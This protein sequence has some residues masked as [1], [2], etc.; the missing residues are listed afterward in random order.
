MTENSR[1][2]DERLVRDTLAGRQEAFSL[3]V[4]R[5]HAAMH[6]LAFAQTG[7]HADADDVA[8]EGFL[9]AYRSLNGLRDA[10]KFGGW[11]AAIVR[12][13]AHSFTRQRQQRAEVALGP[14]TATAPSDVE[15]RELRALLKGQIDL[16]D[17][18]QREVLLLHY[19]ADM[20]A[21]E[22]GE[23][24]GLSKFAVQKR[25]QRARDV[26]GGKVV[27]LLGG[28][29]EHRQSASARNRQIMG[30]IAAMPLPWAVSS[31]QAATTVLG[32]PVVAF[33]L[34]ALGAVVVSVSAFLWL[35]QGGGPEP[36]SAPTPEQ[37][38]WLAANSGAD[39]A[40]PS[41]TLDPNVAN[42]GGARDDSGGRSDISGVVI[43]TESGQGVSDIP[44]R[45]GAEGARDAVDATT[46]ADGRFTFAGVPAGEYLVAVD[47]GPYVLTGGEP[48]FEFAGPIDF[49]VVR[50]RVRADGPVPGL[51]LEVARGGVITGRVLDVTTKVPVSGVRLEA[52][53]MIERGLMPMGTLPI[54]DA[55]GAYRIEGLPA[56]DYKILCEWSVFRTDPLDAP[57]V[58]ITRPAEEVNV[59]D[60]LIDYGIS[61]TGRVVDQNGVAVDAADVRGT[62]RTSIDLRTRF[63]KSGADG[64]FELKGTGYKTGGRLFLQASKGAGLSS[65]DGPW[66]ILQEGVKGVVLTLGTGASIAGV[67]A[68]PSGQP[69]ADAAVTATHEPDRRAMAGIEDLDG[70]GIFL[71]DFGYGKDTRTGPDGSY[72]I[73]GL[74]PGNY[75]MQVSA[76][77][78]KPA[79]HLETSFLKRV[80]VEPGQDL[81]GVN[82]VLGQPEIDGPTISGTVRDAS[83]QPVSKVHVTA[84]LPTGFL[85]QPAQT[86][87]K[88]AYQ[89]GGLQGGPFTIRAEHVGFSPA[90]AEG[91]EIGAS[92]VDLTLL[93]SGSI[94]GQV[95]RADNGA[96]V[97]EFEIATINRASD[98]FSNVRESFKPVNDS[99]GRFHLEDLSEGSHTIFVKARGF[100]MGSKA[101]EN[102]QPG[103]ALSNVVVPLEAADPI[104][105][106]VVTDTG[107][108][109]PNAMILTPYDRIDFARQGQETPE[110]RTDSDGRFT[111]DTLAP[112]L[113][114]VIAV[115]RDFAPGIAAVPASGSG[116]H[117]V[118]IVLAQGGS[119]EGT[120]SGIE[121]VVPGAMVHVRAWYPDEPEK[122]PIDIPCEPDGTYAYTHLA[123]G[124][125]ELTAGIV[126]R[127]PSLSIK[128]MTTI[129]EGETTTADF[130]FEAFDASIEGTVAGARESWTR[131]NV[132]AT[133]AGA[134]GV[135]REFFVNVGADG[136]YRIDGVPEGPV[137]LLLRATTSDDEVFSREAAAE[138]VSGQVTHFDFEP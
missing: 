117:D 101:I 3:L 49:P 95:V 59:E 82:L 44:V 115:H 76:P 73:E 75:G 91:I 33:K 23:V 34:L 15:T 123:P 67:A 138:T 40:T 112:D 116:R 4:E 1:I 18:A 80:Y 50:V 85:E 39:G 54:S 87:N 79:D 27:D 137:T 121:M 89:I 118:R 19:F 125:V 71:G 38:A 32:V 56:R 107:A 113:Q 65:I 43:D 110:T 96:P 81:T 29:V 61:V 106:I 132:V 13:K 45:M 136:R 7:N 90:S 35:P 72:L 26:L 22:I 46:D 109:I 2:A 120:V 55:N 5:Y 58:Q 64:S 93:P 98:D 92:N 16:L 74:N 21:R 25:L 131:A 9:K 133:S 99:Q 41:E 77:G 63:T 60:I 62:W 31:A 48:G 10:R 36:G 17:E 88:G 78:E 94:E 14:D 30:L 129:E 128:K 84:F 11:L 47:R 24:L 66:A 53:L 86:D 102:L 8:Q 100:I 111:L 83:G 69:L 104:S 51:R 20:N 135:V 70:R 68:D 124:A 134:D 57:A 127:E 52:T 119:V 126:L 28:E 114:R 103:Q 108:P 37:I 130:A 12:N 122:G 42:P 105:G 97:T 6:A